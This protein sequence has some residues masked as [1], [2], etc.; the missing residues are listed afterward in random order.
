MPAKRTQRSYDHRLL[1]LVRDT[2]DAS[3]ATR[4]GVPRSTVAGWLRRRLPAV[5]TTPR[6]DQHVAALHT[7]I[8]KLE[9]RVAR[10]AGAIASTRGA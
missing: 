7:R 10:L 5:M 9:A 3:I 1:H 4:I 2:G 6:F 8:A